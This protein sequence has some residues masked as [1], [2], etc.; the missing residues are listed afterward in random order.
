MHKAC[1]QKTRLADIGI[2]CVKGALSGAS[3]GPRPSGRGGVGIPWHKRDKSATAPVRIIVWS[4][5]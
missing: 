4:Y 3:P 1:F 2:S 5:R